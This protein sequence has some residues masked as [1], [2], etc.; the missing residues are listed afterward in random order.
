MQFSV[1][2]L[3]VAVS[4]CAVVCAV[5]S[6]TIFLLQQI[7]RLQ[8]DVVLNTPLDNNSTG[9]I[10]ART[11]AIEERIARYEQDLLDQGLS[12]DSTRFRP[13]F[14]KSST[15]PA[16]YFTDDRA[17]DLCWAAQEGDIS[18]LQRLIESGVDINVQGDGGV[19]ALLFA[20]SSNQLAAFEWLL[21]NGA[22]PDA[23]LTDV[24]RMNKGSGL[25]FEGES[26]LFMTSRFRSQKF[27]F[28]ALQYTDQI[29]HVDARGRNILMIVLQP[30]I[31][32][33]VAM[34]DELLDRVLR[35]GLHLD[36]QDEDGN[37]V[38]I[39]LARHAMDEHLTRLI[40]AG[41]DPMIKNDKGE[42]VVMIL[43]NRLENSRTKNANQAVSNATKKLMA[44]LTIDDQDLWGER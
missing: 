10:A 24:V 36:H 17:I 41:A 43:N 18:E 8:I 27:L 11:Q 32:N 22:D 38:S 23:S 21:K 37:T 7:S 30:W 2:S 16:D 25:I 26:V 34:S 20:L 14:G 42:N 15:S 35:A 44:I 33:G 13:G 5:G 1:K 6:R 31:M 12:L 9:S 19:S 4:I 40:K 3:L 39:Y 28:A 29:N